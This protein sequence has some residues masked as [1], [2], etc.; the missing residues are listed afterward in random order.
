M[1]SADLDGL[2]DDFFEEDKDLKSNKV[3]VK[4]ETKLSKANISKL[5]DK[6]KYN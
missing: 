2:F 6:D 3:G 4:N 5:F 1:T